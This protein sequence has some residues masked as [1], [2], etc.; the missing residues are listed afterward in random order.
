MALLVAG[1]PGKEIFRSYHPSRVSPW[2]PNW[3]S[4]VD[5]SGV[6][7][8]TR[9][10]GVLVS[11]Q[12]V[13]F[14]DHHQRAIG[15]TLVFHDRYGRPY[16]RKLA[17]KMS[18]PGKLDPD[19]TVGLLDRTIPIPFYRV[20][21]P[22]NDWQLYLKGATALITDSERHLFLA[23]AGGVAWRRIVFRGAVDGLPPYY[24]EQLVKGDSGHPSFLLVK[25]EPVLLSTHTFG[26]SGSGP[27]FSEPRN[28]YEINSAMRQL[29]S[30]FQLSVVPLG[31]VSADAVSA[32]R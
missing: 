7:W 6:A 1:P 16:H 10:A 5:L 9:R 21:P 24:Y 12:H 17:R 19:V 26:G 3:T 20:L 13:L 25:G 32:V 29:G 27:F 22:S 4:R 11:P 8:D 18:L 15:E 23:Q 14:S 2:A 30:H 28:F 31:T